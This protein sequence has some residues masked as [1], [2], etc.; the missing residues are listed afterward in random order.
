[1]AVELEGLPS[2]AREGRQ[3]RSGRARCRVSIARVGFMNKLTA[4]T[5]IFMAT[6]PAGL[7]RGSNG[8]CRECPFSESMM[9]FG[10]YEWRSRKIP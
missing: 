4:R 8:P 10:R 1:M 9:T 7:C 5:R 6:D 2:R 3:R